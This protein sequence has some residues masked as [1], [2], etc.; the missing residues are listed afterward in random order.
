MG[1]LAIV[2]RIYQ[3]VLL[4]ILS[5]YATAREL[6]ELRAKAAMYDKLMSD[7]DAGVL[8]LSP[9]HIERKYRRR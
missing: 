6:Q 3:R 1:D 8:R 5:E 2:R 4:R 7:I 9:E